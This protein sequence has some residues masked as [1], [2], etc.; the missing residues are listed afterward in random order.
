MRKS[1][2]LAS[3]L[4]ALNSFTQMTVTVGSTVLDVDTIYYGTGNSGAYTGTNGMDI[5]WEVIY[6]PDD[7]L[8]VTERKGLVSRINPVTKTK[9][10]VLNII[11]NVFQQSESGLLGM[12]LHPNFETTP[13]VFMAYTYGSFSN[14]KEKVVKYTFNGTSLV[15]EVILIDNI[16]GNTT[17]NGSRIAI[18]PDNTLIFSTGD[19]QNTT[20]PQDN[21]EINGKVLRMN[22]DGTIPVDNPIT[23]NPVYSWG[24]RNV[25]GILQHP[26]GKVYLSEHGASTDDEFQILEIGRNYGWPNVEGFCDPGGEET[27]CNANNVIEPLVA[28]TPTIAPSDMVYYENPLI[29]EWDG[30]V[31]MSVLKDK[32]IIA[33]EL[34]T[35]GTAVTDEDHYLTNTFGRLRD[36]CVGPEKEIYLATNGASW[37]NTNP[38]THVIIMLRPQD[39]SSLN[40][41]IYSKLNIYPNPVGSEFSVEVTEN[42]IGMAY[43]VTD[44]TGRTV[45]NGTINSLTQQID[46]SVLNKGI[47]EFSVLGA[48]GSVMSK[49]LVK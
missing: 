32:K 29:P 7:H 23:D 6:G 37:S 30:R 4:L 22:L 16:I 2:L 36:I 31:L 40:E 15:N 35:D 44:L 43:R 46:A 11:S 25:Q 27:F 13:E 1:L 48:N 21:D 10:I 49:K 34:N 18:L 20:L 42:L 19:A 38:N 39:N 28:W 17:H 8:W 41:T 26:N 33:M 47:Y 5:P 24:H 45:L 9:T 3:T 14:I 12:V